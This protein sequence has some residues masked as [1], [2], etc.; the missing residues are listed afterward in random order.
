MRVTKKSIAE[1]L[2]ISRTA[3]SLALNDSPN[4]TLAEET[5]QKILKVAKELGYN[6][7][8]E[9]NKICYILYNREENDPRY[10][11]DLRIIEESASK[12][13]Y[14]ILFLN[15][16][17]KLEGFK[18]VKKV[19]QSDEIFGIVLTG[20]VDDEIIYILNSLK[21]PYIAYGVLDNKKI[22]AVIVDAYKEGYEATKYLLKFGHKRIAFISGR[23]D[24]LVHQLRLQ[25]YK[26]ALE[27]E[28]IVFD[29]S[30]VQVSAEENS[31][32]MIERMRIL[33]INYSAIF[34]ANTVLQFKA[35]QCLKE[36]GINIPG[37]ISVIGCQY[38]EL[39]DLCTPQLTAAVI[40]RSRLA[41]TVVD[42]LINAVKNKNEVPRAIHLTDIDIITGGTVSFCKV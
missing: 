14:N 7:I 3:V 20:P 6:G 4:S 16:K 18:K 40:D 22:N 9:K 35:V 36:K 21:V 1:H 12:H 31:Y 8:L 10:M 37:E 39:I 42:A 26:A 33:N 2:G 15:V 32:E 19:V 34:C 25:G 24:M 27:E 23:L 28:G 30:L 38:T 5:K 29:P 41:E 17:S 13:G 11:S